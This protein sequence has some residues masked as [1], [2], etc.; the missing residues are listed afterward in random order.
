MRSGGCYQSGAGGIASDPLALLS[1][2]HQPSFC[3]PPVGR[4]VSEFGTVLNAMLN[5][6][7]SRYTSNTQDFEHKHAENF[8]R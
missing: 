2:Q 1:L 6:D 4:D 7:V 3:Y 8:K 5:R